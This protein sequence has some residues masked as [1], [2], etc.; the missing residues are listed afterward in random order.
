[1]ARHLYDGI[2][3]FVLEASW[4]TRGRHDW[5]SPIDYGCADGRFLISPRGVS[6]SNQRHLSSS[7]TRVNAG[8]RGWKLHLSESTWCQESVV[9]ICFTKKWRAACL[10]PLTFSNHCSNA[11][12]SNASPGLTVRFFLGWTSGFSERVFWKRESRPIKLR[13]CRLLTRQLFCLHINSLSTFFK[14]HSL[15][16]GPQTKNVSNNCKS[17]WPRNMISEWVADPGFRCWRKHLSGW[18]QSHE[19]YG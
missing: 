17:T 4:F 16:P 2:R 8:I 10:Q 12:F 3:E 5:G 19:C 1:M 6:V 9:G 13:Q 11:V 15:F 14:E 18:A 7:E